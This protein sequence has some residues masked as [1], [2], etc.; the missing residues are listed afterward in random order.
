MAGA[1][2]R[3]ASI[4]NTNFVGENLTFPTIFILTVMSQTG[5]QGGDKKM[6]V[7]G[8][9]TPKGRTVHTRKRGEQLDPTQLERTRSNA[10]IDMAPADGWR[11]CSFRFRPVAIAPTIDHRFVTIDTTECKH[12]LTS[13]AQMLLLY[14]SCCL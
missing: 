3:R 11:R 14:Q 8:A 4:G 9:R 2:E 6:V 13:F 5:S 10:C 1:A 12:N 7:R